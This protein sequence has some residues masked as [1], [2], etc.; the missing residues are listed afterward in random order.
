MEGRATTDRLLIAGKLIL[1]SPLMEDQQGQHVDNDRK[2]FIGE[3]TFD[4]E[5]DFQKIGETIRKAFR[6]PESV[7]DV[8]VNVN[9][10]KPGYYYAFVTFQ[11]AEDGRI[12]TTQ[13]ARPST[14]KISQSTATPFVWRSMLLAAIIKSTS[15]TSEDF[16]DRLLRTS[17]RTLERYSSNSTQITNLHLFAQSA[18][19]STHAC[20]VKFEREE[21]AEAC[22]KQRESSCEGVLLKFEKNVRSDSKH[23]GKELFLRKIPYSSDKK[24]L[25]TNI[26]VQLGL[27]VRK[28]WKGLAN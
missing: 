8:K 26:T 9:R 25:E 24:Q 23:E 15:E 17:S 5:T 16:L 22:L 20:T 6:E 19:S 11:T 21:D 10:A 3:L 1:L 7:Q 4:N 14:T 13:P 2:V 18:G 27:T 12:V 28:N